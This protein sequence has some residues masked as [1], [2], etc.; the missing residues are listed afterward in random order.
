MSIRVSGRYGFSRLSMELIYSEVLTANGNFDITGIPSGFTTLLLYCILRT[1]VAATTD[2]VNMFLNGDTTAANYRRTV[3]ISGDT[4]S[5]AV[6]DD[7]GILT[8]NGATAAA[9]FFAISKV[10]IPFYAGSQEKEI[11]ADII[12]RADA[13][14]LLLLNASYHWEDNS[15]INQITIQPDGFAADELVAGSSVQIF[16]L[17]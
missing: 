10:V 11:F 16:G 12:R 2:N 13:T 6:V 17:R 4:T 14:T 1:D 5:N 3:S 15:I 9:N 7:A 8:A